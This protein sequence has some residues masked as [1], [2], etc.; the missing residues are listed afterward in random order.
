MRTARLFIAAA[1]VALIVGACGSSS[2]TPAA[3]AAA[4]SA[5]P[6]AAAS[7]GGAA[8]GGSSVS[9]K[10]FAFN[11]ATITV[12]AGGKVDWTNGDSTAH[13]V[14]FDDTSITSS[15]NVDAGGTFS[16]TFA[17]AGTFTYHCTIHSNMKGT[18]TVS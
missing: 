11:P 14:T 1:A 4:P 17:K 18:V 9:I 13:T 3:S 12:A 15:G 8:S 5:A 10:N 6:T 2:S 16:T 7:A